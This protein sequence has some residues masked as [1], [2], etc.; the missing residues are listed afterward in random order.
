MDTRFR[1][2][3]IFAVV[4]FIIALIFLW[5]IHWMGREINKGG[6]PD[7]QVSYLGQ[8]GMSSPLISIST[9]GLRFRMNSRTA[10]KRM[11]RHW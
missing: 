9:S 3:L 11:P 5:G 4:I 8:S 10:S 1:R 2:L 6:R 7:E